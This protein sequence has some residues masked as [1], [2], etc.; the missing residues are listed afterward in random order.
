VKAV[1]QRVSWARVEVDG[2]LVG[3]IDR[4]LLCYL[5]VAENDGERELEWLADKV[6]GLRIFP[7]PEGKMNRDVKDVAGGVLV[8]SQFTLLGDCRKGRRPS[9]AGAMAPEGAERMYEAF[10]SSIRARGLPVQTGKFRADMKVSS[11]NDG[12]VTLVIESPRP[13]GAA[14]P[15]EEI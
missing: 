15:S 6:S 2:A 13:E 8:V 12:P 5:G 4:G 11:M 10:A 9:F 1:V 14:R 3:A 7:D